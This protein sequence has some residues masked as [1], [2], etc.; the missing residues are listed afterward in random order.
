MTLLDDAEAAGTLLA[1]ALQPAT[2]GDQPYA[3]LLLRFADDQDF[4]QL[5]EAFGRGLGLR[6]L[7]RT[8]DRLVVGPEQQSPFA[9]RQ[10]DYVHGGQR[11]AGFEQR[12]LAGFAHLGV[13]AYCFPTPDSLERT[14]TIRVTAAAVADELTETAGRLAAD[15][16]DDVAVDSEEVRE[17]WRL[18]KALPR[19]SHT[20]T[21]QLAKGRSRLAHVTAALQWLTDQHLLRAGDGVWRTTD[22]YRIHVARA[23]SDVKLLLVRSAWPERDGSG[24]DDALAAALERVADLDDGAVGPLPASSTTE[25]E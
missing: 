24:D 12:L 3:R 11:L 10:S 16:P 6:P 23:A 18:W 7:G 13:A 2:A 9:A 4:A 5:V 14:L 17:A 22:A 20:E 21:G 1:Y 15:A 19:V 25:Q 8:P